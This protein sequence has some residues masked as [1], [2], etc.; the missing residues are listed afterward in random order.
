[1]LSYL[2]LF[3]LLLLDFPDF[4]LIRRRLVTV[5]IF[6][7]ASFILLFI[8]AAESAWSNTSEPY[9][10]R[11]ELELCIFCIL[12]AQLKFSDIVS[13]SPVTD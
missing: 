5:E 2:T 12:D 9:L 7:F 6:G 1:M 8:D 4:A 11:F 3:F 10:A 13:E